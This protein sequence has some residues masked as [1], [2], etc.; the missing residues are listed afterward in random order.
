MT[1]H[2]HLAATTTFS[3]FGDVDIG[4]HALSGFMANSIEDKEDGHTQGALRAGEMRKARLGQRRTTTANQLTKHG[5]Y[6]VRSV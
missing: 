3:D 1:Q 2:A 4:F 6:A 5:C